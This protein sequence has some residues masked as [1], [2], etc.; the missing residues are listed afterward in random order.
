MTCE[1]AT[2]RMC[3]A[4]GATTDHVFTYRDPLG[5][6]IDLTGSF[7]ALSINLPDGTG[8]TLS[9]ANGGLELGGNTGKIKIKRAHADFP[10]TAGSYP[11]RLVLGMGGYLTPLIK[12]LMVLA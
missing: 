7:A 2:H 5:A 10:T 3:L 1:I 4:A 9:T 11:C 6:P 12:G 8:V